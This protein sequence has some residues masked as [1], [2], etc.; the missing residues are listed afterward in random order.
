MKIALGADHRGFKAKEY[1]KKFLTELGHTAE[2]LGSFSEESVDYPDYGEKVGRAVAGGEF[3]RGIVICDTGIG[4]CIA[5]NKIPNIRAALCWNEKTAKMSRAHNDSNV[6]CL[7]AAFTEPELM[8]GIVKTWLSTSFEG[9]RHARRVGK[10]K[11]LEE[12]PA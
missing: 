7:S 6:L 2:D 3:K 8:E 11:A 9:G 10:I 12:K 4:I 1:L 5:A